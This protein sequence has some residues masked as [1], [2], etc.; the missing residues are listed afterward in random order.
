[1]RRHGSG[2]AG[3]GWS[4]SRQARRHAPAQD[5]IPFTALRK[6]FQISAR[7]AGAAEPEPE[8]T[9][10]ALLRCAG[11]GACRGPAGPRNADTGA[12]GTER[13]RAWTE[14]GVGSGWG[15]AGRKCSVR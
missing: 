14:D 9:S 5:G 7:S 6:N 13:G 11:G 3:A 12:T 10:P 2:R 8:P 15:E 4:A 1:M